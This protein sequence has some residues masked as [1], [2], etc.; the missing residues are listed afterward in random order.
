MQNDI[1]LVISDIV[2]PDMSGV[3][4]ANKMRELNSKLPVI[5]MTGYD[6]K[7]ALVSNN[8]IEGCIILSKAFSLKVL[9]RNI[10]SLLEA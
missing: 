3:D 10:R 7:D 1:A 2:M 6:I 4:A 8:E 5:L 9:S